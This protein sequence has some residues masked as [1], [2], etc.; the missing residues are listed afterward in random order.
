LRE[1]IHEIQLMA[2][3]PSRLKK[4]REMYRSAFRLERLI[5]AHYYGLK[6]DGTPHEKPAEEGD[7]DV[8]SKRAVQL[9]RHRRRRVKR[10]T[11]VADDAECDHS[12]RNESDNDSEAWDEEDKP[13]V[14][15][16]EWRKLRRSPSMEDGSDASDG[17]DDG[18]NAE[19]SSDGFEMV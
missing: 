1:I 19:T 11:W 18:E 9:V 12:I 16:S 17:I 10:F 13:Y 14:Y 2:S 6:P 5:L 15:P 7:R 4:T 3:P 8:D